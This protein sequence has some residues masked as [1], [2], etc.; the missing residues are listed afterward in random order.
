MCARV[1]IR[2]RERGRREGKKEGEDKFNL[3]SEFWEEAA[4]ESQRKTMEK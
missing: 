4:R 3:S 1:V 2:K